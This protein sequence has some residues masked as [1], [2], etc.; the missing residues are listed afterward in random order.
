MLG[1][2]DRIAHA[3]TYLAK[4]YHPLAP[5]GDALPFLALPYNVAIILARH[6]ADETTIVAGLLHHLIEVTDASRRA[7]VIAAIRDRFGAVP[8]EVAAEVALPLCSQQGAPVPWRYR[9]RDLLGQ[10]AVCDPRALDIRCAAELHACGGAISLLRRLGPEYLDLHGRGGGREAVDWY[11]D[12]HL[13]LSRREDWPSAALHHELGQ[14]ARELRLL[15][16]ER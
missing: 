7:R 10:V 5:A 13:A 8:A 12:L 14:L 11:E 1:Y 4:H 3:L 2:S 6:G 9:C 16:G 15:A